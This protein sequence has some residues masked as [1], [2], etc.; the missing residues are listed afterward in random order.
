[1]RRIVVAAVCAALLAG[2]GGGTSGSSATSTSSTST[3]RAP[4]VGD[5]RMVELLERSLVENPDPAFPI[6]AASARCFAEGLVG[7]FGV[8]GLVGL[9]LSAETLQAGAQL[10]ALEL[11]RRQAEG[12]ADVMLECFDFATGV[13]AQYGG[14]VS[15]ESIECIG[16][17]LPR[18]GGFRDLLVRM[19]ANER[20]TADDAATAL[21]G[22]TK[23]CLTEEEIAR[24]RA[25]Q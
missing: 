12:F 14:I 22:V 13:A 7:R 20:V 18:D 4:A 5:D 6:D 15:Q 11:T 1:M 16:D 3:T 9:G 25:R 2:C 17:V 8:P 10:T 24:I 19:M 21:S 23:E